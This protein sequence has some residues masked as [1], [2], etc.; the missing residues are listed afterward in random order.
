MCYYE[1]TNELRMYES[2]KVE[3]KSAAFVYFVSYSY[4]RS[5]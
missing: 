1:I 2:E 5:Y 4:I 3:P